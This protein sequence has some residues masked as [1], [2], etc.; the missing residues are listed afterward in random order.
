[1]LQKLNN[2][3]ST[4]GIRSIRS[5]QKTIWMLRVYMCHDH[6]LLYTCAVSLNAMMWYSNQVNHMSYYISFLEI[7]QPQMGSCCHFWASHYWAL[8]YDNLLL[9]S[10]AF[11]KL[12]E[13][14]RH[15]WTDMPN[16]FTPHLK[17]VWKKKLYWLFLG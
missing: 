10:W 12:T 1:M 11:L 8:P 14:I 13:I 5:M 16:N 17:K 15:H 2:Y 3:H 6:L 7:S 9:L 4:Y